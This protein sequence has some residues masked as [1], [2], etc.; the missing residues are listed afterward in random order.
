VLQDWTDVISYYHQALLSN[1]KIAQKYLAKNLK[2]ADDE[3][4]PVE[5]ASEK[6]RA[7]L[8]LNSL[9]AEIEQEHNERREDLQK[10]ALTFL[11][12]QIAFHERTLV[13][14]KA[15]R[16]SFEP[17]QLIELAHQGVRLPSILEKAVLDPPKSRP[18][19]SKASTFGLPAAPQSSTLRPITSLVSTLFSGAVGLS[20]SWRTA[21]SAIKAQTPIASTAAPEDLRERLGSP[22]LASSS[23]FVQFL[24]WTMNSRGEQRQYA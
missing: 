2:E 20:G 17:N 24:D 13:K 19:L 3:D 12:G 16:A 7:E 21:I 15:A 9:L 5:T 18:A 1:T 10:L 14:L 11:N 22:T 4:S 23:R 6:K 8:V